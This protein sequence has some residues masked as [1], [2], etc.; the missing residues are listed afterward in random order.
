MRAMRCEEIMSL[1]EGTLM[2]IG[3]LFTWHEPRLLIKGKNTGEMSFDIRLY[4]CP[5]YSLPVTMDAGSWFFVLEEKDQQFL[6]SFCESKGLVN[7]N[8]DLHYDPQ[9]SCYTWCIQHRSMLYPV[10]Q[11]VDITVNPKFP[12]YASH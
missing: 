1:P 8:V 6:E 12:I 3:G 11:R 2:H 7:P 5:Q 9:Q 10:E 4:E